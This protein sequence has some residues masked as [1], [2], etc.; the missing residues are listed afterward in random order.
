MGENTGE[1]GCRSLAQNGHGLEGEGS[2]VLY[3]SFRREVWQG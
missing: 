3:Q 1:N 2:V